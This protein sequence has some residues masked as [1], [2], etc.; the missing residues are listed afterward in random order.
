MSI[1]REGCAL[2]LAFFAGDKIRTNII[3]NFGQFCEQTQVGLYGKNSFF[4]LSVIGT[5]IYD[6]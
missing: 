2:R 6:A 3:L 5:N 4:N 1:D